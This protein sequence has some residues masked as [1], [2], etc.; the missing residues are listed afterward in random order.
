ML[1]Y[2]LYCAEGVH[3]AHSDSTPERRVR[4]GPGVAYTDNPCRHRYVVHDETPVTIED[5]A[6][7]EHI[8]DRLTV[9]PVCLQRTCGDESR[10][11]LGIAELLQRLVLRG[12]EHGHRPGAR[13]AGQR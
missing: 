3:E 6:H 2:Y 5:A 4:A 1:S 8:G 12:N 10:L 9:E 7:G 11:M 13:V